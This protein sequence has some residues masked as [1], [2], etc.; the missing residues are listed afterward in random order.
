MTKRDRETRDLLQVA[1]LRGVLG[2]AVAMRGI[3]TRHTVECFNIVAFWRWTD[4][5]VPRGP[6]FARACAKRPTLS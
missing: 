4:L 1:G 2:C 3:R 6:R 5:L